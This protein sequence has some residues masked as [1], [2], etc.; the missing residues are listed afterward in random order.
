MS[1]FDVLIIGA[2]QTAFPLARSLTEAGRRVG[3]AERQHLGGSCVNFGCTP[4]K[5]ALA[6]AHLVHRA[7]RAAAFG[8]RIPAVEVDFPAVLAAARGIAEEAR[9]GLNRTAAGMDGLTL[10]RGHARFTG[11]DG[12]GFHLRVDDEAVTAAQVVVD[13]GTRTAV[14]PIEGLDG[15]PFLDAGN[16]LHRDERPERLLI[17]GGGYVGLEMAQFYQRMGAEVDVVEGDGQVAG[18]ED[19]DVAEALQACLEAEGIRFHLRRKVQRVERVGRAV[20]VGLAGEGREE[21]LQVTHVFVAAGRQ[22]NT[23]DLGLETVGLTPNDD[24]TLPHDDR[25]ATPVKGVWAAGDV[26]GGPPFTHTAWDDHRILRSQLLGD[27][28]RTCARIVPYAL[29][30]DPN[31]GRVGMTERQAREAG[32]AVRCATYPMDRN[33]RATEERAEGGFVK[34][35]VDA[36]TDRI[37]G[38]AVLADEGAELVHAYVALMNADAPYTALRDGLSIHPTR[39]EAVQSVLREL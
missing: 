26:R 29:F 18:Q 5:A 33:G 16:W 36:G 4:T 15:V 6:S 14:P 17:I 2:G 11:R 12:D 1:P 23:G 25:L 39:S 35:V 3:L 7:R 27:G 31:L 34:A 13:T 24:G 19:A 37:L 8:L 10:L 22:P 28:S 30:T 9:E 38:A 20:R 32:H 21:V